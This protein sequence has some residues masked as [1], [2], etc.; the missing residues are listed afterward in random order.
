MCLNTKEYELILHVMTS[1]FTTSP[2]FIY[3]FIFFA[4]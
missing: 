3:L 4:F 2:F 1:F